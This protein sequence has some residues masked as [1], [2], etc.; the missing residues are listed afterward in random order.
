MSS[1][2]SDVTCG[3]GSR[4]TVDSF[5][6][7]PDFNED[8]GANDLAVVK[9]PANHHINCDPYRARVVPACL[10]NIMVIMN[11]LARYSMPLTSFFLQNDD[12]AGW[13]DTLMSGFGYYYAYYAQIAIRLQQ[14]PF[15]LYIY[16]SD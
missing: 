13:T 9:L 2:T 7:H 14:S 11:N 12:Y 8:T 15:F 16:I 6:V 3:R 4:Q 1:S 5:V 10:P